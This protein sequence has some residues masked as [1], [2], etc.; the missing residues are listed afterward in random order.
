MNLAKKIL[1]SLTILSSLCLFVSPAVSASVFPNSKSAACQGVNSTDCS[2]GEAQ[3][4][5]ALANVIN[6]LSIVVGI[7][8]VIMIII[9]G[10]RYVTSGGD[11]NAISSAKNTI[12]Y[13]IVGLVIAVLAQIIVR[14]V[15]SKV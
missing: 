9:G 3:V 8:A 2:G 4:D 14:F 5:S 7:I 6:L 11:S 12:L 10:F 1:M 15:L 13:A